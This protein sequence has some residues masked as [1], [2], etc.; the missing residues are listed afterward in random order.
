MKNLFINKKIREKKTFEKFCKYNF[1]GKSNS[2]I[3]FC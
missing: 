2:I 3:E 1:I